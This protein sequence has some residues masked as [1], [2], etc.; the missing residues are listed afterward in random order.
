MQTFGLTPFG[1]F[2]M[3][4]A[5]S[6]TYEVGIIEDAPKRE[7]LRPDCDLP[8]VSVSDGYRAFDILKDMCRGKG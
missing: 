7:V 1:T 5:A 2:Q 4:D 3:Y 6:V 8:P